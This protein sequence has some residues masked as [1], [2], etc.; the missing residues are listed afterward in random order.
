MSFVFG[1]IL[2]LNPTQKVIALFLLFIQLTSYLMTALINPGIPKLENLGYKD[3][4]IEIK[5]CRECFSYIR[6]DKK[7]RHCYQCKIC[8]EGYD[9]HCPWTSKCIGD[10]NIKLFYCFII[11]TFVLFVYIILLVAINGTL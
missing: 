7:T 2:N 3:K 5:K 8:I 11:S 1:R 10:N 9:H 6:M 4:G